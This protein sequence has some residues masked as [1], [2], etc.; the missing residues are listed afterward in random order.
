MIRRMTDQNGDCKIT[1][2][3]HRFCGKYLFLNPLLNYHSGSFA[4]WA[5]YL[6]KACHG[7][8]DWLLDVQEVTIQFQ[9]AVKIKL[10]FL[11]SSVVCPNVLAFKEGM[12]S[13]LQS[14][15]P[16]ST[17]QALI[18][19]KQ[20]QKTKN[21]QTWMLWEF[22]KQFLNITPGIKIFT[23]VDCLSRANLWESMLMM[24]KWYPGRWEVIQKL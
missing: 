8:L 15:L 19:G 22:L 11:T 4:L 24:Y 21:K 13:K 20:R 6:S 14:H 3:N 7:S 17:A 16:E 12:T 10:E 5:H 2:N 23:V 9:S 1:G 18:L